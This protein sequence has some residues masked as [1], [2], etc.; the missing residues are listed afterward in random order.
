MSPVTRWI[1]KGQKVCWHMLIWGISDTG[2]GIGNRALARMI[3]QAGRIG[4]I[5]RVILLLRLRRSSCPR[6]LWDFPC[7][8]KGRKTGPGRDHSHIFRSLSARPPPQRD[9]PCVGWGDLSHCE[10]QTLQL[11]LTSALHHQHQ[12]AELP[13]GQVRLHPVF[14]SQCNKFLLCQFSLFAEN[15]CQMPRLFL[16]DAV[17]NYLLEGYILSGL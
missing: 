13:W 4:V 15:F 5:V 9:S 8:G 14:H 11:Q 7:D 3:F 2:I 6:G 16:Y 12:Q 10:Q 17:P 1:C